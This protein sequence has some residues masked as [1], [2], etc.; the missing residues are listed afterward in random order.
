MAKLTDKELIVVQMGDDMCEYEMFEV[1]GKC[2]IPHFEDGHDIELIQVRKTKDRVRFTNDDT[3]WD[4][5]LICD[6]PNNTTD[7]LTA[8]RTLCN[9]R[10][11]LRKIGERLENAS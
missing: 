2:Y 11:V 4:I 6:P 3:V 7:A 10:N 8:L 9:E 1:G 5:W